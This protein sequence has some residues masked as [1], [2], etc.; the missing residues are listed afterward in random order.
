MNEK[1]KLVVK[2]NEGKMIAFRRGLHRN[3]EL[4]WQEVETTNRVIEEL[5]RMGIPY[6]RM[7][8]TGVVADLIGELNGKVVALRADMDALPVA[9]LNSDLPYKSKK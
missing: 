3:P 9:E 7:E 4:S 1:I 6:R 8:P 5:E 2:Q